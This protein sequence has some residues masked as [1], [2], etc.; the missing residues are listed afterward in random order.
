LA[1]ITRRKT[2]WFV[3]V[4]RKG[5]EPEY[6][7]F[8]S[9]LDADKWARDRETAIDRGDRMPGYQCL[10]S[11]TLGDLIR[12]YQSAPP[13]MRAEMKLNG[14]RVVELDIKASHLT[15]VHGLLGKVNR[16]AGR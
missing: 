15:I 14:E 1:S 4:R 9:K 5:F 2:G 8:T 7:T 16:N 13:A 3:Q 6:R 10:R 12:R 11:Q